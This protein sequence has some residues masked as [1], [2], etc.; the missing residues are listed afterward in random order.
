MHSLERVEA[1]AAV[2]EHSKVVCYPESQQHCESL[3]SHVGPEPWE[4]IGVED[5]NIVN[6]PLHSHSV[7]IIPGAMTSPFLGPKVNH[8]SCEVGWVCESPGS[9]EG[10]CH[11]SKFKAIVIEAL[12]DPEEEELRF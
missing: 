12:V 8:F 6:H 4:V 1:L 5:I 7:V 11:H 9:E 3:S 2:G 10:P